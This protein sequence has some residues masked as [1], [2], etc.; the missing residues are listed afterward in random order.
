MESAILPPRRIETTV[1]ARCAHCK[2][3][4][5]VETVVE[6]RDGD[7]TRMR[8]T[9]RTAEGVPDALVCSCNARREHRTPADA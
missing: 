3:I 5:Y 4:L 2:K 8:E 1:E 7:T 9:S 6:E